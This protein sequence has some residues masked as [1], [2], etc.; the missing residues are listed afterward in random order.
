MISW[1]SFA[2]LFLWDYV[3][4]RMIVV[5]VIENYEIDMVLVLIYNI[6]CFLFII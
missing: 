1:L 3:G 2:V 6:L 5:A 4:M